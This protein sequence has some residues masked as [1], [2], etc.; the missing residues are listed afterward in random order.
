MKERGN[1]RQ[2]SGHKAKDSAGNKGCRDNVPMAASTSPNQRSW[3]HWYVEASI[4]YIKLKGRKKKNELRQA[5]DG[6]MRC[7]HLYMRA[8]V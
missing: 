5:D 7:V 3:G 8:I 4:G 2:T 1:N 6:W